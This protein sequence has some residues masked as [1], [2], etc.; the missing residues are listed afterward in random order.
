MPTLSASLQPVADALKPFLIR[1]R[2][3]LVA[4][5]GP[6]GVGKS[7]LSRFLAHHFNVSLV[8][9]DLFRVH[10]EGIVYR[11]CEVHRIVDFRLKLSRAI[12][13]EGFGV[14]SLLEEI[15]K[16]PDFVICTSRGPKTTVGR[17][18]KHSSFESLVP[19]IAVELFAEELFAESATE[20]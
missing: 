13:V 2:P 3:N 11:K 17:C 15:G 18:T 7:T 12:I 16:Q 4:V 1:T 14:L 5:S 19:T 20:D 10:C 6:C 8:E 9:L